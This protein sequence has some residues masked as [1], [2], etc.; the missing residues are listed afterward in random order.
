[1]RCHVNSARRSGRRNL[2][3]SYFLPFIF[4]TS[5]NIANRHTDCNSIPKANK[6]ASSEAKDGVSSL[7][8]AE[9]MPTKLIWAEG[10]S[11]YHDE[12]KK[13]PKKRVIIKEVPPF[14]WPQSFTKCDTPVRVKD[15]IPTIGIDIGVPSNMTWKAWRKSMDDFE[16]DNRK[17]VRS[18]SYAKIILFLFVNDTIF[19]ALSSLCCTDFASDELA[20]R[21]HKFSDPNLSPIPHP[22]IN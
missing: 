12:E 14:E 20:A 9:S 21:P 5:T 4:K 2:F 8:S 18:I 15:E 1:M 10:V 7:G 17:K 13:I 16:K 11:L 19:S 6:R 3:L 22:A